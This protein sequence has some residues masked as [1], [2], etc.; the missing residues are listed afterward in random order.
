MLRTLSC[1][2]SDDEDHD[3]DDNDDDDDIDGDME[4]L[5]KVIDG[6]GG[7]CLSA[8]YI[9]AISMSHEHT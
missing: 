1:A 6:D 4:E 3:E 8:I 2:R 5:W 9:M 7:F